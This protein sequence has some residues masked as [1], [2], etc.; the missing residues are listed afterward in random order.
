MN[1]SSLEKLLI[2]C[3]RYTKGQQHSLQPNMEDLYTYK[4]KNQACGRSHIVRTL[5]ML[6]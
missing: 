5:F 2:S 6:E 3:E 1:D 4:P